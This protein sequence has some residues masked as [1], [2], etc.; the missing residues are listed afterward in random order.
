MQDNRYEKI[1][2][3][4]RL[5]LKPFKNISSFSTEAGIYAIG[6]TTALEFPLISAQVFTKPNE[7]IYIGKTEKSQISRHLKTHFESGKSGSSTVRRTLGAI[8][9]VQLEIKPMP[10]SFTEQGTK[11]FTNYKFDDDGEK[12]L[13]KW[14]EDNLSLSYWKLDKSSDLGKVE[15]KIIKLA[16]PI[17]NL[18]NNPDSEWKSEIKRLRKDCR[19]LAERSIKGKSSHVSGKSQTNQPVL[20]YY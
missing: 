11:R 5:N 13:T 15:K 2:E 19:D 14:M 1:L 7:V 8:L 10:R 3:Y 17:L 6:V 12:E 18:Q 16:C 4:L 9:R 20:S